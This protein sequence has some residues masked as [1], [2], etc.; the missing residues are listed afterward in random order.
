MSRMSLALLLILIPSSVILQA[1]PSEKPLNVIVVLVDDLGWMDLSVQGS[2]FYKTPHIDRLAATGTRF[3]DG[4]AACAVCSP[5]RAALMTGRHPHRLG[6]T[7]WIRAEFQLGGR[8][9]PNSDKPGYHDA[10]LNYLTPV[11]NSFLPH[12]E[13][14]VAELV[15]PA[16]YAT[17]FIGKWHLGG[18]GYLPTDQGFDENFGGWDYGQPPS[19]F[20]PYTNRRLAEGIPTLK[21]RKEGEYLTDREADEAVGFINRNKD[22]PFLLY[23]SHYTVHTPIQAKQSVTEK[24]I[25]LKDGKGQDNATYAA[26]LESLDDSMGQILNTLEQQ[27]LTDNTVIIF[28]GDNG[29]LDR[30]DNPTDNAP[31]KIGKGFATEGGIRVPWIVRWPGVTKAGTV[32]KTPITSVDLFPTIAAITRTAIPKNHLLDGQDLSKVLQGK[33]G[34][35]RQLFWHFPHYRHR[36]GADPYSIIR[37][38]DW[39]LIYYYDPMKIELYNL[40]NDIGEQ[41][42]LVEDKA[43]ITGKL[44]RALKEHLEETGAKKPIAKATD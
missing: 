42:N 41:H 10:G 37:D 17:C 29:G 18:K 32:N 26:M 23:L 25:P 36:G 8:Q 40:A 31:L 24:Y 3:T 11:N 4:Y 2:E 7:D 16:G 33:S 22:K 44:L 39:K 15:K 13:L 43:E 5:T 6:I 35:E 21:P 14:T 9:G 34:P 19:Y 1:N 20:D 38:K 30:N 12:D 27:G 28:T